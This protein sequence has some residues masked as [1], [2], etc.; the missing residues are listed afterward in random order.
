[1]SDRGANLHDDK[2]QRV[3]TVRLLV[4]MNVEEDDRV[5]RVGHLRLDVLPIELLLHNLLNG[6]LGGRHWIVTLLYQTGVRG[7]TRRLK[8]R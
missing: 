6:P 7:R 1:M 2:A 4:L 3:S 5:A 8:F